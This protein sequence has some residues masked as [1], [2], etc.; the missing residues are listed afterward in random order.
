MH[1]VEVVQPSEPAAGATRIRL[2]I[3]RDAVVM[4]ELDRLMAAFK[5][6]SPSPRTSNDC[7]IPAFSHSC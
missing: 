7:G 1:A 6:R 4:D 3:L 2:R 5:A